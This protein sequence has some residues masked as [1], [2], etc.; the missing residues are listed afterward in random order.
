MQ[1][2]RYP[3]RRQV[4]LAAGL[5]LAAAI[6]PAPALAQSLFVEHVVDVQFA[7]HD[8]K[9]LVGAEVRVFAP[10]NATRPVVTGRTDKDGKFSFEADRDG[11]WSAEA[12]D[13]D[14]QIARLTIRVGGREK[15]GESMSPYVIIG[16]LL[17]FLVMVVWFRVSRA[18]S[19][20][21]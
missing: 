20:R 5:L 3:R 14:N 6:L 17:I 11:M 15:G 10:G 18:R 19:R 12:R 1:S 2:V 9:P 13:A 16:A 7:S 4:S 21:G 8:G